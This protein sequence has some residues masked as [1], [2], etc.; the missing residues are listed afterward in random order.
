VVQVGSF[1]QASF[2][3]DGKKKKFVLPK[4][5]EDVGLKLWAVFGAW[6]IAMLLAYLAAGAR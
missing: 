2:S 3:F 4:P 6:A 5:S 1:E